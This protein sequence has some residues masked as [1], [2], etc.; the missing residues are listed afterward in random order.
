MIKALELKNINKKFN[1]TVALDN[2]HLEINDGE[3]F[4]L[5]G[6]SGSG[7]TTCLKV[8]GGFEQPDS[9]NVSLFNEN[10]TDIPPFKRN[11][12]TVF[13]DYALFPHMNVEENVCYSLKIKKIPKIEQE[14]QVEEILSTVK[15]TGY[16]KRKPSELSGGQRQRVALARS[17]INKPKILLL[18]EPLGAL[19]LKLREQMQIELKNLQRQFQITFIY[20]T[21]DQ[22][23][24]LSMS[25]R[26]AIFNDG[27]I[28][29]V[30]TPDNIYKNPKTAFV[31]DFIGTTSLVSKQLAAEL[32]NYN[33]A[34]S[35][36]PENIKINNEQDSKSEFN[37]KVVVTDIQFQG[38]YYKILCKA[39]NLTLTVLHYVDTQNTF[40]IN[41]GDSLKLSWGKIDI[42]NIND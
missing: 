33:S 25:D 36:R 27:K 7:K 2:I 24:A 6:P 9:G 5:L 3:F 1:E 11:V 35:I 17:L 19:D 4:S 15:L 21:H 34:F 37:T 20:V 28:E 8:I 42:T 14:S 30:D 22:Q 31:A 16:E 40:K 10:V 26:I 32:F 13:Q 41:L 38:S 12:N 18:D 23:E 29:Q 39:N